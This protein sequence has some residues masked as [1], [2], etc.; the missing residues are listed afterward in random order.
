MQALYAERIDVAF[1]CYMA[2]LFGKRFKKAPVKK[3]KRMMTK[4]RQDLEE[5]FE[6]G[7]ALALAWDDAEAAAASPLLRTFPYGLGDLVRGS[8]TA[9]GAEAMVAVA[10]Q[11][12]AGPVDEAGRRF[13][14]WRIKN[15]HHEAAAIVGGSRTSW[16]VCREGGSA[17]RRL[18]SSSSS[19]SNTA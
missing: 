17:S 9:D 15:T 13:E 1:R 19:S 14:C 18:G 5:N 10:E 7:A 12:R 16:F 4:L 6:D 3:T 11:L 2:N 8:V